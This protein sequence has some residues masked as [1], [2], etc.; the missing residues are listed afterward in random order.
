MTRMTGFGADGSAT[1]VPGGVPGLVRCRIK[2][3]FR[4]RRLF[5]DTKSHSVAE[6]LLR[7]ALEYPLVFEVPFE[8]RSV[9]HHAAVGAKTNLLD[10]VV[11][12]DGKGDGAVV[13]RLNAGCR[14]DRST[15]GR[16]RHVLDV[17]FGAYRGPARWKVRLNGVA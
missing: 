11:R 10:P 12:L 14:L 15:N 13:D 17:D 3:A 8:P 1:S 7:S 9:D 16:G 2:E 4:P 6:R 5:I